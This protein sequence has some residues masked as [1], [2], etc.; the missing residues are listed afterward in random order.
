MIKKYIPIFILACT[1]LIGQAYTF[2]SDTEIQNW[3]LYAHKPMTIA[4]NVKYLSE[5]VNRVVEAIAFLMM[6][7]GAR[8]IYK[9]AI[10]EYLLYRVLDIIFYFYNFKTTN[11]WYL[12]LILGTIIALIYLKNNAKKYEKADNTR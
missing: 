1:Y 12:F 4:W 6:L 3:I 5:E 10:L 7:K 9:L 2:V 11:Y 8:D